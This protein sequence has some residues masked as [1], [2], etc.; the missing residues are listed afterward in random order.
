MPQG[1][2]YRIC[3]GIILLLLIVYLGTLVDF[4]FEPVIVLVTALFAPIVVAGVLYYLF[5]PVIHVMSHYM[6]LPRGIAI[7][8]LYLLVLGA[9]ALLVFL[10][11][12]PLQ[13]QLTSLI[14]NTP[15]L[16]NE[17]QRMIV[18]LQH[19]EWFNRFLEEMEGISWNELTARAAEYAN[20]VLSNLGSNVV[21]IVGTITSVVIVLLILPFILYY[22]LKE[23]EK[24]PEFILRL[25][26]KKQ[27][28]EGRRILSDMDTALSSYIQGQI[29][30]SFFVGVC[31]LIGYTII[32]LEYSLVLALVA[33]FTNVIPFIGPWIGT[34]PG[35]V[36]GFLDSPFTALL[37]IIV[38]VIVQ[39]L[40][41][42]LI[43]PQVM[44]KKLDV[45][46]VTIILLLLVA[47]R[48]AG[49]V[50][51]LLA[52]PTYAVLKVIVS[53]TYRLLK[54]RHNPPKENGS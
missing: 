53:H 1:K 16:I 24:A 37:V 30:V 35:V 7:L 29:I 19:Q 15:R 26:P 46:P 50:G 9:I 23:G 4:M 13:H 52:V 33:M 38:V 27:E 17:I 34:L 41:S 42:N 25:L 39:Q 49:L 5:R 3:Y 6:K 14:N 44:G 36:V 11:G 21:N 40:E 54:L 48:F 32:G 43:S 18:E 31:V 2:F 45:H 8:L 12:P 28:T 51:L 22:M 10:V 47:G 20:Q